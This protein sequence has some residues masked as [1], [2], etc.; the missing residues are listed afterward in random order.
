MENLVTTL[1]ESY[2]PKFSLVYDLLRL[3]VH[4]T[5]VPLMANLILTNSCNLKCFYCYVDVFNRTVKD[6]TTSDWLNLLTEL[7]AMGTRVVILL[8]GEPLIRGD[9]D[10]IINHTCKLGMICEV[11]TNGTFVKK[12][13]DSLKKATSVCLSLDGNREEHDAN[14]G[15]GSFDQTMEA[16][17]LL[18]ENKIPIRIKACIT[19]NNE[20]CLEFLAPFVKKYNIVFTASPA[21]AYEDRDYHQKNKWLDRKRMIDFLKKIRELKEQGVPIGYSYKALDYILNWPYDFDHIVNKDRSNNSKSYP[22]IKCL[23]K[24]NSFYIDADGML[25]SCAPLWGKGKGNVFKDGFK[26]AWDRLDQHDCFSC[27]SLPDMDISLFLGS[28]WENLV[29]GARVVLSKG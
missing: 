2:G 8:G 29:K 16:F 23:R 5:R 15:Q 21:E 7:R 9:I 20:N 4:R 6:P 19:K 18:R 13:I 11:I 22:L 10:Q 3:K 24:T 28:Y 14:R 26:P 1:K 12:K 27:A 17:H 25:Y